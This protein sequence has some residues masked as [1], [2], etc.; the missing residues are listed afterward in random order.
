[1]NGGDTIVSLRLRLLIEQ[2]I[3]FSIIDIVSYAYQ[4]CKRYSF[5]GSSGV[6]LLPKYSKV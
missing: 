3:C 1:M 2:Q 4:V 6:P 5:F